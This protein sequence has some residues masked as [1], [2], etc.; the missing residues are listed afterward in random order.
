MVYQSASASL[1]SVGGG[2]ITSRNKQGV[3]G[4]LKE[5]TDKSHICLG[6]R[7]INREKVPVSTLAQRQA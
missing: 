6:E 4:R 5:W 7:I 3:R 2:D 1:M